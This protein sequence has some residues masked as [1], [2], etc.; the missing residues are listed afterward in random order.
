MTEYRILCPKCIEAGKVIQTFS[1]Y[2]RTVEGKKCGH[3]N[4]CPHC[5]Y[6]P[7][8]E[9]ECEFYSHIIFDDQGKPINTNSNQEEG[10]KTDDDKSI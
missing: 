1:C 3:F 9:R 8:T 7:S 4:K 5:G 6:S 2:I 10:E